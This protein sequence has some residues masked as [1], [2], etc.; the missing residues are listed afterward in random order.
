M[1][2]RTYTKEQQVL[3]ER[4]LK[5][6]STEYYNILEVERSATESEIKKAYRKISLKVHP[7][8]NG[9]PKADESFK[10]VNKAFEVLGDKQKRTIFDQ[11]GGE[12]PSFGG[13][14]GGGSGGR[15]GAQA[16]FFGQTFPQGYQQQGFQGFDLNEDFIS[17]LFGQGAGGPGFSFGGP[18]GFRM[19]T[20]GGGAFPGFQ[21]QRQQR[22]QQQQQ[23]RQEPQGP[24]DTSLSGQLKQY[25][26]LIL[27][28]LIPLLSNLFAETPE[29]YNMTPT[30]NFSTQ[31]VTTKFAVPYYIT[32]NQA[33]S[34]SPKKLRELDSRVENNYVGLLRDECEK[35]RTHK[36]MRIQ[37]AYGWFLP[38]KEK[39]TEAQS[40]R[41]PY[42]E[43]LAEIGQNIL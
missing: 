41:L 30:A 23:Q 21:Q 9:H 22:R 32:P 4:V 10:R 14:G 29:R 34:L 28:L 40:I 3:V 8:K 20:N 37:N 1:S 43:R 12:S 16:D 17:M 36:E 7:D 24:Q 18:G 33:T 27:M 13:F 25:L 19:Y 2:D 31:R 38:D 11:T 5:H 6:G 15:T 26:P 35:E 39:L 42:C